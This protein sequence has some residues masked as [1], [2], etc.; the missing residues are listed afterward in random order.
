MIPLVVARPEPGNHETALA[1]HALGLEVFACPLFALKELTWKADISESYDALFI[2]SA[3]ALRA[4]G[5]DV[6]AYRHLPLYA[7]GAASAAAARTA[8]FTTIIEGTAD[9]AALA[10]MAAADG[11]QRVLHLAGRPH[12]PIA[13][14]SLSFD[15][16]LV[17]EMAELPVPSSLRTVLARPCV[18]L[19]H[20]PRMARALADLTPDHSLCHLV[21]ISA[22][23]A[24]AAGH[25][26]ASCH[27]PDQPD[28]SAMLHIAAP[29]CRGS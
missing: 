19:A 4:A 5:P 29:L 10:A 21:T 16:Q 26:W 18:V 7:V 1:A 20:S 17:Y 24:E 9:G 25:G 11:R 23:A 15:V 6:A 14:P 27:W 8:G 22:Q 13:H 28:S 12:K 2:T 3:N